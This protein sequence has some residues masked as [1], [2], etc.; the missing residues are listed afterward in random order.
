LQSFHNSDR[1]RDTRYQK[2]FRLLHRKAGGAPL[3]Q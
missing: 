3:R 1:E 2:Q